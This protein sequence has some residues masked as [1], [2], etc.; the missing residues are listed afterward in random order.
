VTVRRALGG[1]QR[2]LT[3]ASRPFKATQI[4]LGWL[5]T[6][7]VAN[8]ADGGSGGP[9]GPSES[10]PSESGPSESGPSESGPSESGLSESAYLPTLLRVIIVRLIRVCWLPGSS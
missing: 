3:K 6:T 7:A 10:G 4:R 1:A 8:L 9:E 5:H 2:L